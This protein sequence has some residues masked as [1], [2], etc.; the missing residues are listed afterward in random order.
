M[1]WGRGLAYNVTITGAFTK[2]AEFSA[3]LN[4]ALTIAKAFSEQVPSGSQPGAGGGGWWPIVFLA[5]IA[6]IFAFLIMGRRH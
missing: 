1:D 4:Y 2:N 6:G 5:V 3:G